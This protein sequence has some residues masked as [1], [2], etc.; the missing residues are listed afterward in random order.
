LEY[1]KY[2]QFWYKLEEAKKWLDERANET[3]R[4]AVSS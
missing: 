2:S 1:E 4:T 3:F